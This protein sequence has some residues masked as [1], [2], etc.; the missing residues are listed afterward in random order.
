VLGREHAE[1]Y[2]AEI[3]RRDRMK[4]PAFVLRTRTGD[5]NS[6]FQD[7]R[8]AQLEARLLEDR[9]HAS[10][11]EQNQAVFDEPLQPD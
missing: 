1:R 2:V 4:L 5:S 9:G 10:L 8:I 7:R 3:R 6:R 11:A